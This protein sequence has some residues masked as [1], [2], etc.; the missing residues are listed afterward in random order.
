M[1][2]AAP[3]RAR[4]VGSTIAMPCHLS[5]FQLCHAMPSHGFS[6][7]VV[8][9]RE[10]K[11]LFLETVFVRG[12]NRPLLSQT[13]RRA[14]S[15]MLSKSEGSVR[16]LALFL[17]S[18]HR[19]NTMHK[20]EVCRLLSPGHGRLVISSHLQLQRLL[21]RIGATSRSLSTYSGYLHKQDK[22]L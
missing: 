12:K 13:K 20:T 11:N 14:P 6:P 1:H 16:I 3:P 4:A 7:T 8:F 5:R 22:S 2:S 17:P 21:R 10:K 18:C 19:A 9:S 15:T